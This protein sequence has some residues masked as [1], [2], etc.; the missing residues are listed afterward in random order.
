MC[1][2]WIIRDEVK[3][4]N[5]LAFCWLAATRTVLIYNQ[6]DQ[7]LNIR[8]YRQWVM[9][10]LPR[11]LWLLLRFCMSCH[12]FILSARVAVD[13]FGE[14]ERVHLQWKYR[15]ENHSKPICVGIYCWALWHSFNT[16]MV[17]TISIFFRSANT[18]SASSLHKWNIKQVSNKAWMK[19]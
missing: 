11:S 1:P 8:S 14:Q 7:R 5:D 12:P 4:G 19:I 13:T 3:I 9:H 18:R 10:L 6:N 15:R 16:W 17:S 2:L